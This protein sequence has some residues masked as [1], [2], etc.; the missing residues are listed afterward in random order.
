MRYQEAM[1]KVE[2]LR[3]RFDSPY[4]D[5][6]KKLIAR[7][8][9]EVLRKEFRPTSCQQCYHD[10][11][12]EIYLTLKKNKKM[13]KKCNYKLVAGFIISCPD[14]MGGKI[15]SNSNLTDKVAKEYLKMYPKMEKYFAEIPE[16]A[17]DAE[18]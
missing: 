9:F 15:F 14:F 1:A 13:P 7:L 18:N 8:Y 11:V 10:A 5:S 17:E 2:E 4:C 12:I 3:Q 6:D 16:A